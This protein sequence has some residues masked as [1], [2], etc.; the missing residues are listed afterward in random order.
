MMT[1]SSARENISTRRGGE[2]IQ[3]TKKSDQKSTKEEGE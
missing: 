1:S 2:E 3:V